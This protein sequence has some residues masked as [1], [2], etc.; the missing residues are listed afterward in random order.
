MGDCASR[1][2]CLGVP[3]RSRAALSFLAFGPLVPWV[4]HSSPR[5]ARVLSALLKMSLLLCHFRRVSFLS[6]LCWLLLF[7]RAACSYL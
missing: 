4:C 7:Q 3:L 1:G 2:A 6:W 5:L